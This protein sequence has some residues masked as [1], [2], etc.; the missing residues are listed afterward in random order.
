[1]EK[2]MLLISYLFLLGVSL[3]AAEKSERILTH[4]SFA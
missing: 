1:M 3:I 2:Y 4:F